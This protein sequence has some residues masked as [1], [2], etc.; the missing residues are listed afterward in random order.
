MQLNFYISLL[1]DG[2]NGILL[3]LIN[4]NFRYSY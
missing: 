4:G 2:E 1:F 3:E